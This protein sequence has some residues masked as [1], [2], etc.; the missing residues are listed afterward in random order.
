MMRDPIW[1]TWVKYK[2]AVNDSRV[3]DFARAIAEHGF[4]NSQVCVCVC[5][6]VIKGWPGAGV[7]GDKGIGRVKM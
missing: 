3:L 7:K 5:T 6:I 4:N 1:S 2:T